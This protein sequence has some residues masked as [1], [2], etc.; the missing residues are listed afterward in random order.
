MRKPVLIILG[1]SDQVRHKPGCTKVPLK[2][3]CTATENG[4]RPEISDLGSRGIVLNEC[5]IFRPR[6][7]RPW[8]GFLM[9]LL[10]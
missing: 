2:P 8:T 6:I 1:V 10:I 7:F 9:M 5:R 3:D 4:K